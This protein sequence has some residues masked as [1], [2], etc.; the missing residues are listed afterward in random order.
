MNE[1]AHTQS[2]PGRSTILVVE[3]ERAIL[4]LATTILERGGY[5]VVPARSVEEAFAVAGVDTPPSLVVTD[6]ALPDGSGREVADGLRERWAG[7][8]I[9]F[10]S[11]HPESEADLP[12]GVSF[13]AKPFGP[14]ELLRAV[15]ERLGDPA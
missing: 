13:L 8:S 12:E 10:V 14:S 9:V 3:D 5:R 7:L 11:G 1:R 4:S 15:R 6:L 2:P